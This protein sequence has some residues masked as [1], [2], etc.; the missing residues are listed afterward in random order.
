[1]NNEFN[2]LNGQPDGYTDGNM[3]P[4]NINT[5][6][7]T[8]NEGI[9]SNSM[10]SSSMG[11]NGVSSDGTGSN[12][13]NSNRVNSS[14][15]N[16]SRYP[17]YETLPPAPYS[18]SQDATDAQAGKERKKRRV[19][20][21]IKL[22]A[23]AMAFGIIA[24][25]AFQGYYAVTALGSNKDNAGNMNP[26]VTVTEA[27]D[28][29]SAVA[30][31]TSTGGVVADV[32]DVVAKVMPSIVAINSTVTTTEY[33]FF[34]RSY[35]RESQ[36]S[37]SG[38]IIGQDGSTL[39]IATNNHVISGATNVQI[40]FADDST[41]TGTIKGA[42]ANSDLAVVTVDMKGLSQDTTAAIKIATLGD[43]EDVKAGEMAIAIGNA[44]GY[45]QSVTVGYIS[46]VNRTVDINGQTMTLLQ[47]DAAINPGNSGGALLNAAGQ[48]IGINS[49]KY[50]SEEIEGMGYAI[51]ISKAVPIIN[52]LMNREVVAAGE[53]GFLGID[54]STAQ[55]VTQAYAERFNM[56][57]GVYVNDIIENSP[58]EEAGLKQG[59]IITGLDSSKIETIDD[60]V[61]ALSFKK[62]GQK[63]NLVIQAKENGEYV[64]KTLNVTL[65]KKN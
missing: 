30:E 7:G 33:D 4:K 19:P 11:G 17:G 55:E 15:E 10:G 64:G 12:E 43:S 29:N 8:N 58:A 3:N 20:G 45:G 27:T 9:S 60:L 39:Y 48:V 50:A 47:T 31:T 49:I 35:D 54:A 32:S 46:A 38:I 52:E 18:P 2:E 28:K 41:A 21:A 65:G 61:N 62:A 59:D 34:G 26:Q 1:M 53:Q 57:I 24:G 42:D 51:P 25:A 14:M 23:A 13:I 16:G 6:N 36:G 63:V 5:D 40:I 44:L 22:V 56:P 37:G